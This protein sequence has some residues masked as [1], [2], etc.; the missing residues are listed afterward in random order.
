MNIKMARSRRIMDRFNR[1]NL[2]EKQNRISSK[3]CMKCPHF[4]DGH[5]DK[6]AACPIFHQLTEIGDELTAISHKRKKAKKNK[7]LETLKETGLTESNYLELRLSGLY[8][9][10]IYHSVGMSSTKFQTWK[11]ETGLLEKAKGL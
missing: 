10:E 2:A 1:S 8:D 4:G 11:K 9:F 7:L 6:C 5:V 3:H